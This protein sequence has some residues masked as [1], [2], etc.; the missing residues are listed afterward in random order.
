MPDCMKQ[1]A[2][3]DAKFVWDIPQEIVKRVYERFEPRDELFQ[4]RPA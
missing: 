1:D 4:Q 3:G 2:I